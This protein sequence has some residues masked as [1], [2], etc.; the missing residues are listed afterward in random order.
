MST[1]PYKKEL[2]STDITTKTPANVT[3]TKTETSELL[4]LLFTLNR[5]IR[6]EASILH[7]KALHFVTEHTNPSMKEIADCFGVTPPSATAMINRL[8][9]DGLLK[10]EA[11]KTDRRAVR[12]SITAAGKKDLDKS[13]KQM[14]ESAESIASVLSAEERA[15]FIRILQKLTA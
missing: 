15:I 5:R 11:D 13:V 3:T 9:E 8:V 10:R 12:I 6:G 4:S 2:H 14:Q 1:L 7:I